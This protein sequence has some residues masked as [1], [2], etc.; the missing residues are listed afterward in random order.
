MFYYCVCGWYMVIP[1]VTVDTAMRISPAH[2]ENFFPSC[3]GF[4]QLWERSPK[5]CVRG[6][7]FGIRGGNLLTRLQPF[8]SALKFVCTATEADRTEGRRGRTRRCSAAPSHWIKRRYAG[9]SLRRAKKESHLNGISNVISRSFFS[10]CC[11][12][13]NLSASRSR[14][15]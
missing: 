1:S 3:C 9:A 5:D 13:D 10:A 7:M 11:H 12:F 14:A 4:P 8:Y 2:G 15:I 6:R